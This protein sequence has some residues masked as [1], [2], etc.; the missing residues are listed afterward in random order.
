MEIYVGNKAEKLENNDG[1]VWAYGENVL[2]LHIA[3]TLQGV[4]A[5]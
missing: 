4:I 1:N 3:C 5:L 2:Q